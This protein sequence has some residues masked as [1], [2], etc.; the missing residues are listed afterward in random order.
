MILDL[1]G[2]TPSELKTLLETVKVSDAPFE[3]RQKNIENIEKALRISLGNPEVIK[4]IL[5][6]QADID[7]LGV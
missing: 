5:A 6:G 3:V 1:E 7:D 2:K 4:D